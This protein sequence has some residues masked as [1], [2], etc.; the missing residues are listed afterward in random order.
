MKKL[1]LERSGGRCEYCGVQIKDAAAQIDHVDALGP[2]CFTNYRIACASCNGSKGKKSL[3]DYRQACM[4]QGLR[5][6]LPELGFSTAQLIWLNNQ[7]WFPQRTSERHLF[8]FE[9]SAPA[10]VSEGERHA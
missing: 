6:E 4:V 3:E 5:S 10:C 1:L 2:D 9:R 8:F 7:N